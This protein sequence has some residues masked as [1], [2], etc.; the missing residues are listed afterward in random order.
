MNEIIIDGV[1]V[2]ECEYFLYRNKEEISERSCGDGLVNCEGKN[3]MYKQLKRLEAE[4][5]KLNKLLEE[6]GKIVQ[7]KTGTIF[8]LSEQNKVLREENKQM[9]Q[10]N[11][12]YR[13]SIKDTNIVAIVEE[14]ERLKKEYNELYDKYE[15]LQSLYQDE[16]CDNLKYKQALEEIR[17][18]VNKSISNK[19]S[20][21]RL[22]L[23]QPI[24]EKINEVLDEK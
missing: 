17:E 19:D 8:T 14:N 23:F 11:Q 6:E 15:Q 16:H 24:I 3:C 13:R 2:A 1:N 21:F 4:N 7:T 9:K 5:E 12:A 18:I 20:Y 22:L 10:E